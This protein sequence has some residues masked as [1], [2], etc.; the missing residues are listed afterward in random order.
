MNELAIRVLTADPGKLHL[1]SVG[2]AGFIMKNSSGKLLAV[3]LY[4][5]NC[6]ERLEGHMGF[7]RLQPAPIGPEELVFDVLVA[8]HP[9]W[10]H[11]DVDSMSTLMSSCKT[12]LYA[13]VEC[14]SLVD[15]LKLDTTRVRYV[16]T[17]DKARCGGYEL[18]FVFCDH[19]KGAPD[20][21]GLVITVDK[22][23][24]LIAGDTSLRLDKVD[25]LA[26]FGPFDVLIAPIN[27]AFGNLNERQCAQLSAVLQPRLTIP[28]H[29]GICATH[30]GDPW[31]FIESM[32]QEAPD[33]AYLLMATAEHL[34]IN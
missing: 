10:D 9:H 27:G 31:K 12:T 3:D 1:F 25:D 29:Y 21:V 20:A 11:F 26:Q 33:Q 28:C 6:V 5:S 13:S 23:K 18:D 34:T 7:K 22:K 16:R 19:G 14:A 17:G 15:A 4:L 24:I 30:G 8:T 32:K 2:Q